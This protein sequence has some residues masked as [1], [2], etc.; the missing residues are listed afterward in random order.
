MD[1]SERTTRTISR[2]DIREQI[3]QLLD[4]V[5]EGETQIDIQVDGETVAGIVSGRDLDSLRRY[6]REV[7]KAEELFERLRRPFK[8]VDPDQIQ[9]D[10][11]NVIAEVRHEHRERGD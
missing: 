6:E 4:Q 2:S 7:S 11:A 8:E 5:A 3:E 10:A 1:Y 9:R